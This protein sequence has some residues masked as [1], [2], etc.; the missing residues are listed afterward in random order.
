M[1]KA[2][3]HNCQAQ[4]RSAGWSQSAVRS[5]RSAFLHTVSWFNLRCLLYGIKSC[6]EKTNLREL[7]LMLS[8]F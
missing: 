3:V 6:Y 7:F 8:C 2:A 1:L 5:F 4:R